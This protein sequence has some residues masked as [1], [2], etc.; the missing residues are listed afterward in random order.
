MLTSQL[1]EDGRKGSVFFLHLLVVA[2]ALLGLPG[3]NELLHGLED[4]VHAAHVPV[5]EVT[6]VQLKEPVIPLI[7][8]LLPVPALQVFF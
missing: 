2:A 5:K 8:L 3:P 7:L 1:A 6:R 4:L